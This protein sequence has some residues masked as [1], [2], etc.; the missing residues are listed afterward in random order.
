MPH[1]CASSHVT[2]IVNAKFEMQLA[3]WLYVVLKCNLHSGCTG[4]PLRALSKPLFTLIIVST[5]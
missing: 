1:A 4:A 2:D 5:G 3:Q